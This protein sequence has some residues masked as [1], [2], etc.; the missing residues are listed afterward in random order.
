MAGILTTPEART[1]QADVEIP[2]MPRRGRRGIAGVLDRNRR[3]LPG[4]VL[5]AIMALSAVAAPLLSPYDPTLQILAERLRPPSMAHPL[6]TD[7]FGRDMLSRVLYAG[8][9]SLVVGL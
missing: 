8:R 4:L 1:Q 6:G 9:V 7:G 2:G 5:C 3:L